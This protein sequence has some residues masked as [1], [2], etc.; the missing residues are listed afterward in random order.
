MPCLPARYNTPSASPR[1][2]PA[3]PIALTPR[4][5]EASNLWSWTPRHWPFL[6]SAVLLRP[7]SHKEN[8]LHEVQELGFLET[9]RSP[10]FIEGGHRSFS[11]PFSKGH[12]S[13]EVKTHDSPGFI[14]EWLFFPAEV[15]SE[16][17]RMKDCETPLA[18]VP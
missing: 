2:L 4:T 14:G 9:N 15:A 6:R 1:D 12:N 8:P 18:A 10:F 7:F 17:L 16:S 11:L 13:A 3:I 5:S